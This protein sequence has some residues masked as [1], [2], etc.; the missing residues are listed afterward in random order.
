MNDEQAREVF[1]AAHEILFAVI[2]QQQMPHTTVCQAVK[3]S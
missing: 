1:H 3:V 2:E